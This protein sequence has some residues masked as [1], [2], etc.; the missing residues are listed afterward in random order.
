MPEKSDYIVNQIVNKFSFIIKI[1]SVKFS[2]S[3]ERWL[4]FVLGDIEKRWFGKT[5]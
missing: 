2:I 4:I 3:F 1:L 5:D